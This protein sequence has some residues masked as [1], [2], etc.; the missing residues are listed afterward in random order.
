M[1][2]ETAGRESKSALQFPHGG[3]S[4]DAVTRRISLENFPN[5]F[6]QTKTKRCFAIRANHGFPNIF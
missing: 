6:F 4:S 3:R 5:L 1:M 2:L